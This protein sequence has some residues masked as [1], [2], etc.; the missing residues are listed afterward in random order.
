MSNTSKAQQAR[1]NNEAEVAALAKSL[2][3][4]TK[5]SVTTLTGIM[6]K[7]DAH[8]IE[9]TTLTRIARA[10]RTGDTK[11]MADAIE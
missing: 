2:R 11:N 9:H 4:G 7:A 1:M 10:M 3:K 8:E 5:V 6:D